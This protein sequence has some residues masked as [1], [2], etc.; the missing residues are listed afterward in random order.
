LLTLYMTP[1]DAIKSMLMDGLFRRYGRDRCVVFLSRRNDYRYKTAAG[2]KKSAWVT[3][4]L[5][6]LNVTD[7]TDGQVNIGRFQA[8]K[9][10]M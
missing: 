10:R 5:D 8:S 3:E 9:S 6:E 2:V 1:P 4:M 7:P